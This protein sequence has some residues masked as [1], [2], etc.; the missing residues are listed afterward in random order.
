M[1][2]NDRH[3]SVSQ[4][5]GRGM[6][7]VGL[8]AVTLA[9]AASSFAQSNAAPAPT[10]ADAKAA[11]QAQ[12][13]ANSPAA[14]AAK[15]PRGTGEGIQVH[16]HWTIVV[17]NPDG[18]VAAR[19]E[20]ENT[21]DPIEGADLLTGLLSGEYAAEG[22][23]IDLYAAN[24]GICGGTDC[25]I[26]DSR[27]P[28]FCVGGKIPINGAPCGT[29]TYAANLGQPLNGTSDQN[30]IGYTLS[31]SVSLLST[32]GGVITTVGTGIVSCPPNGS[33][34]PAPSSD[35]NG[36]QWGGTTNL[37]VVANAAATSAFFINAPGAGCIQNG[38]LVYGNPLLLTSTAINPQTVTGGQSIA[39]TVIIT[40]TGPSGQSEASALARPRAIPRAPTPAKPPVPTPVNH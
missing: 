9:F 39:A 18:T 6:V 17:R 37:G 5:A 20:F 29:L 25:G 38:V 40:F 21:L 24:G 2:T 15:A 12:A 14:Q 23:Y 28:P 1:K 26:Y 27:T 30:A 36:T 34:F 8:L 7:L 3:E 4:I 33:V 35:N 22:F 32:D 10:A 11:Q 16:G 19:Q 31:G 13:A